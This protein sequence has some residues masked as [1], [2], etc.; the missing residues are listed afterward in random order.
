MK[1]TARQT[2]TPAT[3]PMIEPAT[4]PTK[5]DGAV[6]AT[7]P[8]SIPL[9]IIPGFGL[10]L[11]PPGV[12]HRRERAEAGCQHRD[13]GDD[14]D[15]QGAVARGAERA[16]GVEPEP[17]EGQDERAQDR[18]DDVVARDRVGRAVLVVLAD[19]RPEDD[20]AGQGAPAADRVDDARAGEVGVARAQAD[21]AELAQPAAAPRP[22]GEDRVEDRGDEQAVDDERLPARSAR[23]SSRSGS[24]RPCP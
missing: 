16:A 18:Q 4:G 22:V 19:P 20:R 15:P 12:D 8:A 14:P 2:R 21:R 5:P 10:P 13:D 3:S 11:G 6:I 7:S 17:A 9:T 23:P 24:S 1:T